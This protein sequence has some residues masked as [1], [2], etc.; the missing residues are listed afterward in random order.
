M[1]AFGFSATVLVHD[2]AFAIS[3]V[4]SRVAGADFLIVDM[5]TSIYDAPP[6]THC[7]VQRPGCDEANSGCL[8]DSLKD[9]SEAQPERK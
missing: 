4:P 6:V 5:S 2:D 9:G 7:G 8:C 3:G 1:A